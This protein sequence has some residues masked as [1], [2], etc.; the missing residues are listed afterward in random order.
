[1]DGSQPLN[2]AAP[3]ARPPTRAEAAA[4]L[5]RRE[6]TKDKLHTFLAEAWP[7]FEGGRDF[8]DGWAIGAVCD[9][10]SAVVHGYIRDLVINI[11]PR[12][13]KSSVVGV[14]LT[15][16][17]WLH[18]PT[19]QFFC[20]SYSDKLS[21]RDHVKARR[22]IQS[23]WYQMRWGDTFAI[24]DDQNTKER[25]DNT[26]GGYRVASST[27]GTTTGEGGDILVMDDP[28][29]AKDT[30]DAK[31][32]SVLE[33]WNYVMPT[34]LNDLKTGR[35]IVVQQRVHEKDIT[36]EILKNDVDGNWVKLI[37]PMEFEQ[38]RRAVTVK[39]PGKEFVWRDPRKEESE[40]L[41]PERVGQKELKRLKKDLKT[42]YAIAGQLQQR[43]SP[44]EGGIIKKKWFQRWD[45][46]EPPM[47]DFT[48]LSVDTAMSDDK[49]DD[50]R[51]SHSAATTWG[52][53]EHPEYK[54]PCVILLS[55]WR[56]IV[57]YPDLRKR[58]IRLSNHYLDNGPLEMPPLKP[59][60]DRRPSMVLIEAKNNGISLIQE[61]SRSEINVIRF[62]PDKLGDKTMRVRLVTPLLESGKVYVPGLPLIDK[63]TG[64]YYYDRP[65]PFAQEFI[66]QAANFPKGESRDLVDTMTQAL[67]RLEQSG[68]IQVLGDP[69]PP[70]LYTDNQGDATP[71]Y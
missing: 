24:A 56:D 50:N 7:Q 17:A 53:F 9:H 4:E 65:R 46:P 67:W 41:W 19:L 42:E 34:R 20:T 64:K 32:D 30:S 11:P 62:N 27:E 68:W 8:T 16:W 5:L 60:A 52:V 13:S 12:M 37:L 70:P 51:P 14:C 1:M 3:L 61:L 23:N 54:F 63:N 58:I 47:V 15:P 2:G 31:L 44:G 28:N 55:M 33:W 22:L 21:I 35:R 29:S 38:K 25:F 66:E 57:G 49:S 69:V 6:A 71:I 26:K 43:P 48:I 40:L 36:G 10:V 39:L 59:R 45:Y 18:Y